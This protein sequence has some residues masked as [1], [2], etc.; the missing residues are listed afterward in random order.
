MLKYHYT[1]PNPFVFHSKE[2]T[3]VLSRKEKK[4]KMKPVAEEEDFEI[5]P[6]KKVLKVSS[7]L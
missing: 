1:P 7:Q 4:N 5:I 6:E 2:W 3:Q